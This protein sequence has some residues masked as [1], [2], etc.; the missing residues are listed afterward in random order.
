MRKE[1]VAVHTDCGNVGMWH[2]G[3]PRGAR[4]ILELPQVKCHRNI[5]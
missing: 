2:V 4:L 3:T 1:E 5:H